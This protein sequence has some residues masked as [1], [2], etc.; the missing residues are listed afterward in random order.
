MNTFTCDY[1]CQLCEQA[2]TQII[3]PTY[4]YYDLTTRYMHEGRRYHTLTHINDMLELFRPLAHQASD[5]LAMRLA[6][7]FHD[8]VYIPGATG[9]EVKSWAL[10]E[11]YLGRDMKLSQ[12]LLA[13]VY[14]L[15]M[16]TTHDHIPDEPDLRLMVD[17]DLFSLSKP[18]G[19]FLRDGV[20]IKQEYVPRCCTASE[21]KTGRAKFF[22]RMLDRPSI[23]LTES[24][25]PHEGRAQMNL[26]QGLKSL[27][28]A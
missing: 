5:P 23:F 24:F 3:R 12:Y 6:I 2:G 25:R 27:R 17:L 4:V 21:F 9:N 1:W 15:I 20:L 7:I 22:E 26:Q 10:A 28:A 16:A 8:A 11:R 14:D 19:Q 13:E 18:Y